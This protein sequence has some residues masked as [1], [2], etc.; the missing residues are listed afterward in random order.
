MVKKCLDEDK[1]LF[2]TVMDLEKMCN[3]VDRKDL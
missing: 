1:E 3:S 2:D